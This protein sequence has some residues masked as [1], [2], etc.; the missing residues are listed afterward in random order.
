MRRFQKQEPGPL[1]VKCEI[2][3]KVMSAKSYHIHMKMS[4]GKKVERG[5][6]STRKCLWCEKVLAYMHLE[7]HAK[8]VHFWGKFS[9][10]KCNLETSSAT[11][12]VAHVN[13]TH[14][15]DPGALCPSCIVEYPIAEIEG[16]YKE[17]ITQ[18][19]K[20]KKHKIYQCDK[21]CDTCGKHFNKRRS[22][23]NHMRAHLRE[24]AANGEEGLEVENLFRYCDQC[25]MKFGTLDGLKG[26]KSRV[27]ENAMF[28]C[29]SCPMIFDTIKKVEGH[30]NM[31]HSTDTKF[32]CKYCG[33]RCRN[34]TNRK[35]HEKFHEMP[36]LKCKYCDKTLA[37]KKALEVHERYHTGEKNFQCLRC[38]NKFVSKD[39]LQQH[40]RGVHKI[41]GPRGGKLGWAWGKA[42]SE[43]AKKD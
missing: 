23:N 28:V 9:C 22:Y 3:T 34:T 8:T 26:H 12:L 19:Y 27:H 38:P 21:I 1:D 40:E 32:Q 25:D 20:E 31:V 2:C 13:E 4:H 33:K 17:C 6:M 16:H 7:Q 42:R 29:P 5:S 36:R 14:G 15:D 41:A 18:K 30:Q 37:G 39:Q 24:R 35:R 10:L 11:E 43:V